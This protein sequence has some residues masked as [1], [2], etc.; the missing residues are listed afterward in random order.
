MVHSMKIIDGFIARIQLP[1]CQMDCSWDVKWIRLLKLARSSPQHFSIGCL[2]LH[3]LLGDVIWLWNG[4]LDDDCALNI[5]CAISRGIEI[6]LMNRIRF[7]D[8]CGRQKAYELCPNS[9]FLY[10]RYYFH[11]PYRL[12]FFVLV[13][14]QISG[15]TY[16]FYIL[17]QL[18]DLNSG[19][20]RLESAVVLQWRRW[21]KL[22]QWKTTGEAEKEEIN[23][24]KRWSKESYGIW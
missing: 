8:I 15:F 16:L 4:S 14:F 24:R 5:M 7:L 9:G 18:I 1:Y 19:I 3:I 21:G 10:N 13:I 22:G 11:L 6:M 12:L 2:W 20:C 23:P 17:D